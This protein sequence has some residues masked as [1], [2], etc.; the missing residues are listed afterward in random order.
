[1]AKNMVEITE[2]E[3]QKLQEAKDIAESTIN[4][5]REPLIVLDADLK[6][7]SASRAFYQTFRVKPGETERRFIYELGNKQWDIPALRKLLEDILP[8]NENFDNYEVEHDFPGLGRRIMLLNARRIPR[9]PARPRVILLAFEDITERKS[10]EAAGNKLMD[11]KVKAS[12]EQFRILIENASD[13]IFMVNKELKFVIMNTAALSLLGKK[14]DEVIGKHVSEVFPKEM[15]VK[16]VENLEKVLTTGENYVV[17]EELNFGANR[18]FVNSSLSPVKNNEGATVAVLG[19][20]RDI[21][22]R[23]RVEEILASE[24]KELQ[25][26]AKIMEERE[27][28]IIELKNEIKR[29]K[30]EPEKK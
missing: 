30:P 2:S 3:Y 25:K 6:V 8:K 12:E 14:P 21:S 28:R 10:R 4:T 15:A 11:N 16:N 9:P 1:M 23:K 19:V 7:V 29:L 22:E 20:V 5:V 18:L 26:M 13:Q 24:F 27:D 17:D